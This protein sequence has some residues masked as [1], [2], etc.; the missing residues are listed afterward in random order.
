MLG[1]GDENSLIIRIDSLADAKEM[2][3]KIT[4]TGK[5]AYGI[6]GIDEIQKFSPIIES[7]KEKGNYK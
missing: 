3:K 4:D 1:V 2:Q 5:Y 7:L 6:S